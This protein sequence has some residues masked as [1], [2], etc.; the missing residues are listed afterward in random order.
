MFNRQAATAAASPAASENSAVNLCGFVSDA[1]ADSQAFLFSEGPLTGICSR[2]VCSA[3]L[4]A[5]GI[6]RITQQTIGGVFHRGGSSLS[7]FLTW[8]SPSPPPP[9]PLPRSCLRLMSRFPC[10][11]G[12]FTAALSVERRR[13]SDRKSA[14]D[15]EREGGEGRYSNKTLGETA[16]FSIWN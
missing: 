2:V 1:P 5:L 15:G 9:P 4:L 6:H 3:A 12:W 8:F 13:G 16:A 7:P 10:F 14:R 11:S